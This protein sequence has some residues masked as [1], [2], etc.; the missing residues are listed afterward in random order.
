MALE[1]IG[2]GIEAFAGLAQSGI[3]AITTSVQGKKNR[4]WATKENALNRDWQSNEASLARN[5]N[6]TEALKQREWQENMSNTA[7]QR[8]VNDLKAAGLNPAL[9]YGNNGASTPSG[10]AASG[11]QASTPHYMESGYPTDYNMTASGVANAFYSIGSALEKRAEY[12]DAKNTA[13]L[14]LDEKHEVN[15]IKA[16][17]GY[18][19]YGDKKGGIRD[20]AKSTLLGEMI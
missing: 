1:P 14:A 2:A 5:F 8:S 16:A 20:T 11:Q 17:I 7:Y 9:A 18:L 19:K 12:I 15:R 3:N 13:K 10:A 4:E 6:A